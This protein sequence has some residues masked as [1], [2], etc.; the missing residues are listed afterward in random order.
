MRTHRLFS[1]TLFLFLSL[2]AL[3]V[4]GASAGNLLPGDSGY[5][6][7]LGYFR[8]PWFNGTMNLELREGEDAPQGRGYAYGISSPESPMA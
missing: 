6:L 8:R 5:E 4:P 3:A 1:A 2:F 7:G